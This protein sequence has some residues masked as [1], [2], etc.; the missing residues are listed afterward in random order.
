MRGRTLK[1]IRFFACAALG[2]C[3]AAA[4][5]SCSRRTSPRAPV[6]NRFGMRFVEI[7]AGN[8]RMGN[9]D[10]SDERPAHVVTFATSF[11]MQATELTQLQ[12]KAVMGSRPWSTVP[13]VHEGDNFPAIQISWPDAQ[14][15]VKKLNELDP[16][17]GYRLP[18][19]A[20]WEYACRAGSTG[21]Y[22]FGNDKNKL[23]DHAWF[24][25][26]ASLAGE[27]YAHAVGQKQPNA[28]GLYD[29]HGNVWE[30]CQDPYRDN[31]QNAPSNGTALSAREVD[32]HVYRGGGFRNAERF[33]HA[34]ARSGL[35]EE[36]YSDNIGFRVVMQ[37]VGWP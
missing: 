7:P 37:T 12:W 32:S 31:Y 1:P 3:V 28:W 13:N 5:W 29:M 17:H 16:G 14:Q 10:K 34:S 36:D 30:W 25:E 9:P 15:F 26:N 11:R 24:D 33:T 21:T 20:E 18:S 27:N 2:L 8:Y 23:K 35:D 22:D 6:V 19:E 4:G